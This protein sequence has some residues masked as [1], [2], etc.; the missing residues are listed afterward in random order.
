VGAAAHGELDLAATVLAGEQRA[1]SSRQMIRA[2]R[3]TETTLQAL[4]AGDLFS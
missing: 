2:G 3:D 4:M 1:S